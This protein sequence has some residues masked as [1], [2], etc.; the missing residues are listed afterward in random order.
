MKKLLIVLILS[1]I[2]GC[3]SSEMK[4]Q[5]PTEF[6]IGT[7]TDGE[8]KGIYKTSIDDK[9]FLSKIELVAETKNPSFLT[10]SKDNKALFAVAETAEKGKGFV[11]SY[12]IEKNHLKQISISESGGAGPCFVAI[13]DENYILTANYGGG[14]V[15]LLQADASGKLSELLNVQQHTGKGTT[16]RQR[17]PHAHSAWFHPTKKEI[18]AVDL[19]TNEL[20]FSTIDK[21]ENKLVLANPSK[22]NMAEGAGPR[23]LTFHPN[24]KWIYV[25][26]ELNNTV[27]L[28]KEK[29]DFYE[30]DA[31]ISMIPENFT[32]FSKAADIH[33]SKDGKFVY[34]SNRG[35]NS[36]VIYKVNP[37]N[38]KLSLVGYESVKGE[39]PRNFSL[40]PD[41]KFLLVVNQ[42]TNNIISFKRNS[43]TG[44]LTFVSEI[45]A[46]KPVCIL[47]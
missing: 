6:Y 11:K 47:F 1:L 40:T 2:I 42:D 14:N 9:G 41:D 29:N 44:K 45:S 12:K 43:E 7:Y 36:I 10:K 38:G 39:S 25:L 24:Y 4:K 13:N 5:N 22:L 15:G 34:A 18:I 21:K 28:V 3:K 37:E 8:S 32:A 20:W 33:I 46:P 26:N 35:H 23:H 27:S 31:S 16:N 30:I 17:K 19:G